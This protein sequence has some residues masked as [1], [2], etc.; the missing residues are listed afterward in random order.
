MR[1][2]LLLALCA[3]GVAC[4]DPSRRDLGDET[5]LPEGD[6]DSDTDADGDVDAD[7]RRPVS[8]D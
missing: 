6:T 7:A 1:C 4:L 3:A 8:D 5:V 2:R